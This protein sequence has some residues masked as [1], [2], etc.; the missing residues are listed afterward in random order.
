MARAASI[1]HRQVALH[2]DHD[3]EPQICIALEVCEHLENVIGPAWRSQVREW[4]QAVLFT[5]GT[6]VQ[7]VK[8]TLRG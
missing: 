8:V 2:S 5:A 1:F 3:K 7:I 6:R 4:L